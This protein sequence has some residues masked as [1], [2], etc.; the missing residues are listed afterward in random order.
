FELQVVEVGM[1]EEGDPV[2]TCLVNHLAT[3]APKKKA[4]AGKNQ[5]LDWDV[6]REVIAEFGEPVPGTSAIP[7]GVKAASTESVMTRAAPKFPG[8]PAWRA[9]DRVSQAMVSLQ[10]S[11]L[12]GCHGDYVWLW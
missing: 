7:E 9:R 1:D 8:I 4:P 11:G 3:T 12:I 2:T 5:R 6:I 10:A